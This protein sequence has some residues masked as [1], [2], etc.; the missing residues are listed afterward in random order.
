MT[1]EVASLVSYRV[2]AATLRSPVNVARSRFAPSRIRSTVG[3][4]GVRKSVSAD[5]EASLLAYSGAPPRALMTRLL[6][7]AV[8]VPDSPKPTVPVPNVASETEPITVPL[9]ETVIAG[10]ATVVEIR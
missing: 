5:G 8:P 2:W 10:P 4:P 9:M 6:T 3:V 1:Y 7:L